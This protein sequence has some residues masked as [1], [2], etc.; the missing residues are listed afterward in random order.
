[1]KN[2][3]FKIL[4]KNELA[5]IES[6]HKIDTISEKINYGKS[7]RSHIILKKIK[8]FFP[9]IPNLYSIYESI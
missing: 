1:M 8:T 7:N 4:I 9:K 5:R 2:K 6:I 3:E